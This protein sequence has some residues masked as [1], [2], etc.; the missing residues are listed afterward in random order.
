[1]ASA[2]I[3]IR[4]KDGRYFTNVVFAGFKFDQGDGTFPTIKWFIK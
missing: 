3:P 4:K 2:A 1:M